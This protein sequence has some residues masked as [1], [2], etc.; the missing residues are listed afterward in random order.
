LGITVPIEADGSGKKGECLVERSGTRMGGIEIS[1]G[2]TLYQLVVFIILFLLLKRYAFGP[3]LN[4]MQTRQEKVEKDLAEAEK[5]RQ[6][7][8]KLLSEQREE[9][10]K[11]RREAQE[12]LERAKQTADKQA[13]DLLAQAREEAERLKEDA[14]KEIQ[15]EKEQALAAVRDQVGALSVM[16]ASKIIEKEIDEAAQKTLVDDYLKDVG[17]R[18]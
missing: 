10:S 13:Q 16:L 3:L 6:E 8:E 17:E 15:R 5:N 11:V 4:V 18:I 9:M 1:W 7:A 14:Q 2:T 12:I